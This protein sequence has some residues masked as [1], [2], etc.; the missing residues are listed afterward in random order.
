MLP[1]VL[2][3]IAAAAAGFAAREFYGKETDGVHVTDK[4]NTTDAPHRLE[5][6]AMQMPKSQVPSAL[7]ALLKNIEAYRRTLEVNIPSHHATQHTATSLR[8]CERLLQ[9]AHETGGILPAP[10]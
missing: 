1:F 8:A 4:D 10:C 5:A 2:G 7:F 6:E 9:D 3:G